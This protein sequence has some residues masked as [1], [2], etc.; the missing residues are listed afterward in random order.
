MEDKENASANGLA[1][2]AGMENAST[3]AAGTA[4]TLKMPIPLLGPNMIV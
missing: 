4:N 1:Q 3:E 2:N